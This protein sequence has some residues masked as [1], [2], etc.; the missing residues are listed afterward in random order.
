MSTP[1]RPIRTALTATT[2]AA[3]LALSPAA[4][5]GADYEIVMCGAPQGT[6]LGAP[7]TLQADFPAGAFDASEACATTGEMALTINAP[8]PDVNN[9][10]PSFRVGLFADVPS[11]RLVGVRGAR[12]AV[13]SHGTGVTYSSSPPTYELGVFAASGYGSFT[14]V[15]VAAMPGGAQTVRLDGAFS[16]T[17][18]EPLPATQLALRGACTI[19]ERREI[20]ANIVGQYTSTALIARLRDTDGP[21][22]GAFGAGVIDPELRGTERVY[23]SASD[24]GV[25]VGS[26][27]VRVD[28]VTRARANMGG[29]T[30]PVTTTDGVPLYRTAQPCAFS[31]QVTLDLDTTAVSDGPHTV[32]VVAIDAV[33]N[34]REL[35]SRDVTVNNA[36]RQGAVTAVPQIT[37]DAVVAGT[38]RIARPATFDLG[39]QAPL[40]T[41]QQWL[42]CDATGDACRPITTAT[43]DTRVVNVADVGSTLRVRTR[44]RTAT[45]AVTATSAPTAVVVDAPVSP[46]AAD[47]TAAAAVITVA[48]G[49]R[50]VTVAPSQAG[51]I[52]FAR[53][54]P[55]RRQIRRGTVVLVGGAVRADNGRLARGV[56]VRV[57]RRTNNGW[58]TLW[59]GTTDRR[60]TFRTTV[61]IN[62]AARYRAVSDNGA[63]NA[64]ASQTVR[65]APAR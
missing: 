29:C 24:F 59:S 32:T 58:R 43:V 40:T 61:T 44:V 15:D 17:A 19:T 14:A 25:G 1:R 46:P 12:T 49:V 31:D 52:S 6:T 8:T 42:R 13:L 2:A 11:T 27:E 64:L 56:A 34:E 47:G 35:R 16:W 37:G 41:E 36:R 28:G 57:Q 22:G 9:V 5:H 20:C 30:A 38:L 50:Q 3:A 39:G 51:A 60:A 7:W 18:P 10:H 62:T 21:Q 26:A 33:G 45:A 55:R 4:A 48:G 65:I 54:S 23:V 53:L 63:G